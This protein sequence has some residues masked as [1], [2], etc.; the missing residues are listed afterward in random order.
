LSRCS[1][2]WNSRGTW[3]PF[4]GFSILA[5]IVALNSLLLQEAEDVVENKIPIWLFSKEECLNKFAPWVTVIGHFTDD[6][7]NDAAVC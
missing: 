2:F 1:W 5:G 7:D 6:L 4:D 3:S